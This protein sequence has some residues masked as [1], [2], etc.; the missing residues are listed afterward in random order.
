MSHRASLLGRGYQDNHLDSPR[1]RFRRALLLCLMTVVVPGSGHIAA[2]KRAVGWFAVTLWLGVLGGG[3]YLFWKFRTD[4]AQVLNWFTDTDVLLLARAGIVAVAV[5]WGILFLDAWRLAS[6]F[7]LNFMRAALIT[8]LNLAIIGG[9]AGSTAY[10]SQLIKVS[11][12][13]VKVV[14]KATKTSEPLKGRYN[15]LLLGSD[16]G[17]DRVGIRPD[18]MTVA[19][20]DADTGKVVLISL[21]RNLQNVP[22]SEGSPMRKL[23]PN[24]YSC[25]PSCLLNAVHTTAQGRTDLYPNSKDPGLDATIDAIQGVTNLK[26][27]YYIMVNM[28]GFKGLVNAVGGVTIDVKSRI[29]MFGHEDTWKNVYIEPGKQKLDGQ[30]ALWYARS[31]V[32]SDDYTRMGRQKCLMAAMANQ[33]SPQTVLLNATKIANSGKE[34]LETNLPAKELGQFADLTLKSRGEKIRTVSVVPPQFNTV[35]PD[36]PAIHAAIQKAIDK[37]EATATAPTNKPK[38]TSGRQANQTEDLAAVC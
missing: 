13:T 20:I 22:F 37:S 1:V 12:D 32:Q 9:V 38:D 26:I 4:R 35:T 17:R 28:K 5:L 18:S 36:F 11:R 2:G 23:Y 3:G 16:A 8:V 33:L 7:R 21:P 10:A 15:I 27:N 19:S 24:G 29:A 14:F 30:K 25:G 34:L 6:P 31:R